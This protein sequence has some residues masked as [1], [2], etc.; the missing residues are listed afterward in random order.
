M[1]KATPTQP[2]KPQPRPN[3][4]N[5]GFGTRDQGQKGNVPK[6]PDPPPPPKKST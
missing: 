4:T 1:S 2:P 6:M 3:Q 5:E